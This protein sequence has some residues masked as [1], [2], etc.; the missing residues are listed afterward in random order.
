M[1]NFYLFFCLLFLSQQIFSQ[2]PRQVVDLTAGIGST[3]TDKDDRILGV[4]AE[5]K[6]LFQIQ[7][8]EN[9]KEIWG[10]DGRTSG[11]VKLLDLGSATLQAEI[12][13]EN[14][15]LL[16]IRRGQGSEIW[17]SDGSVTGTRMLF[18]TPAPLFFPVV[19]KNVLYYASS[20]GSF[21]G[22][23]DV[24]FALSLVGPKYEAKNIYGF[25]ELYG[26]R[27]L[28]ALPDRLIGIGS[29]EGMGQ[30]LF[31]S[32]G[33]K[34][35]TKIFYQL[36][37]GKPSTFSDPLYSTAVGNKLFFFYL[38]NFNGLYVTD[39]TSSGTK[40]LGRYKEQIFGRSYLE[41]RSF[42]SWEGKFFYAADTLSA[43]R[44]SSEILNVSDGTLPGTHRIVFGEEEF[45]KPQWF[46]PYKGELYFKAY[47]DFD[48]EY[49]CVT[50]GTAKSTFISVDHYKLGEGGSFGGDGLC[51]FQDSLF[52]S[53]YRREVGI[54]LWYSN[55]F[56]QG[57]K[58]RDLWLGKSDSWPQQLTV[59][60]NKLFFTALS[61][62][63]GRELWVYDPKGSLISST[64]VPTLRANLTLAP[65][66]AQS[67]VQVQVEADDQ[68][69]ELIVY[70]FL[71][72]TQFKTKVNGQ[73]FTSTIDVSTWPK[74]LYLLELWGNNGA[75][76][77]E[78]LMVR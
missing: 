7:F 23:T 40:L 19:L 58:K 30:Y 56:T 11:T 43:D 25:E 2:S 8:N 74:G 10:S 71:G 50:K 1:K 35:G 68:L 63:N 38:T 77:T 76:K 59:A 26:I 53:A 4:V 47:G 48:I 67:S 41:P 12:P 33:T 21:F 60:G 45:T 75:R 13:Y 51:V 62:F 73:F 37:P 24:L 36:N 72:R 14:G 22:D 69:D 44:F 64:T 66:P 78:K 29:V 42:F 34:A 65:N 15:L 16:I 9:R 57:T 46:T 70:D 55:G 20:S 3:F 31:S 27:Q 18:S 61:E 17:S 5:T 6:I 39:G 28:K 52:F 49:I 54:E 32:D